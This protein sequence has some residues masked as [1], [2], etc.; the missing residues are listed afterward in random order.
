MLL[1]GTPS[2]AFAAWN[3]DTN[4]TGTALATGVNTT[5]AAST[6]VGSASSIGMNYIAGATDGSNILAA[7]SADNSSDG[8]PTQI[9]RVV[10]TSANNAWNSAAPIGTQGAQFLA[11]TVDQ[12]AITVQF[13]WEA[14]TQG[15]ANLEVEYTTDGSTWVNVP[16]SLLSFP[17]TDTGLS[18]ATNTTSQNTVMGGY[19]INTN[20]TDFVD[21]L[22]VNLTSI[23]AA[24]NDP[25]FGIRFVNASTGADCLS[26]KLAA[27]NNTSG[28]W[29]F[30]EVDIESAGTLAAPAITM[31]P[32]TPLTVLGGNTATFT[33]AASGNP[34]PTVQWMISTSGG[35]FTAISGATSTTYSFTALPS[36]TGNQY[37]AVFTNLVNSATTQ[38]ATLTVPLSGPAVTLQPAGQ[39]GAVGT[40]VTFTVAASGNP[41]PTVQWQVSSNGGAYTP[42]PSATS[43]TYT[44]TVAPGENGNKYEAV[45]TGLSGG[46]PASATSNP[47]TLTAN[48]TISAWNFDTDNVTGTVVP[49]GAN[50]NPD[51]STG[52]GTAQSE[53]MNLFTGPDSSAITTTT[54]TPTSSSSDPGSTDQVWKIAGFNGGFSSGASI[55]TQGAQFATSTVG[56][57]NVAVQFDLY[58][59]AQG[60]GKFQV[61]YTTDGSTWNNAT[62]LSFPAT[63]SGISIQTNSTDSN[64]V[65]GSYFDVTGGANWYDRLTADLSGI[66]AANNN[67]NFAVRIVNAATG[68]DCVNSTGAALNN[69]SGNWQFDEVD[70]VGAATAPVS[71][72]VAMQPAAQNVAVGT[73]ATFFSNATGTPTPTVQWQVSSDGTTW[74]PIAGATATVFTVTAT[75]SNAGDEYEAVFTNSAGSITS[76]PAGLTVPLSA[77]VVTV[78][79]ASQVSSSGSAVTFTSAALGNPAPTVQWQVSSDGGTNWTTLSSGITTT[80]NS[81]TGVTTTT[82]SF[83]PTQ[84]NDTNQYQAVF[85]NSQGPVPSAAATLIVTAPLFT[86]WNFDDLPQAVNLAPTPSTGTGTAASVGMSQAGTTTPGL[87]PT[88]NAVGPDASNIL[89]DAGSS[90]GGIANTNNQ[91]WRIVGTNG[92]N[93]A[94]PIGSQGAQF[95]VSTAGYSDISIQFDLNLTAQGEGNLAVEYTTDGGNTW[96][97]ATSLSTNGDTGIA[98]AT[99]TTSPNTIQ[100]EYFSATGGALWYNRLTADFT[101]VTDVANNP[102]FGIRLVNASTGA[103][104]VNSTGQ[105]LNNT[106]GNMRF[107]EVDINGVVVAPPPT[108]VS[109]TTNDGEADGNTTQASEVRQLVVTFS[110]AVNLTQPGAFSLGVY[111]LDG[112][113]GAVSG[114]GANDGSITNISSVL[115]TATTTDGG[116]TWTIT[117]APSTAH[118]DASASLIDGIYSFSINNSDVTS[119]GVALTGSNTYTFHRLY[120]DVTGAGAVNNTDARD[121]SKAYG[122]AAGSANYNAAFDFGGAGANINNTDARDFSLRY[123]QTFSSVL[124]AGG[125]D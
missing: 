115:N 70:I 98:V 101:G 88:P 9:W 23:T 122:A 71:L 24:N 96:N 73:T 25:N 125:I 116:L 67:A 80:Y 103:D 92:W 43:T 106:S 59:T 105:A 53:G 39:I 19:F 3:F 99:N 54:I 57:S 2:N 95:L 48:P 124:P 49:I 64:T 51:P 1:T 18:T 76:Q 121:F 33:A 118:T 61:Q 63:D 78:Q 107:D 104:C 111:N 30:D 34:T 20:N 37:E 26:T 114:N 36:E 89:V 12:T 87:Y 55:G 50:T 85:T 45:F 15:E 5:P 44:F 81:Q 29:R 46:S 22:N 79:P 56:Y 6:G 113:G 120:G 74:T 21:R 82:Y 97:D 58:V 86:A 77:P 117:F 31:Q 52:A 62:A 69:T 8:F 119:G 10:G 75:A 84:A 27:L 72:Q 40:P 83:T 38:P 11:S 110:Q 102:N 91:A 108:V 65:T 123:G 42:I 68:V 14:T 7:A 4:S 13:D 93:S 16:A 47:A 35:P 60:E 100:G 41:T 66:P 112:T 17:G 28:N 94:A 109:V 90:D 32:T